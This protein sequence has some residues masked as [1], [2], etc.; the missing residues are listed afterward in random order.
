M[1]SM[2]P[3]TLHPIGVVRSPVNDPAR[4]QFWGGVVSTIELDPAE[5]SPEATSGLDQFS[6]VVVVF[7]LHQ[8]A[9]EQVERATRHPR[10]REDWPKVGILAQRAKKRPNRIGVSNC[11]LLKV[12][13]LRLTVQNLDAFD[14]TPVLDVKPY[15]AEFGPRGELREPKWSREL[16]STY[17]EESPET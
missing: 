2:D 13:G 1:I 10:G 8:V 14:G 7:H 16:M 9:A 11:P 15:L 17:F 6:H 5:V 12:D 4:D 3:I